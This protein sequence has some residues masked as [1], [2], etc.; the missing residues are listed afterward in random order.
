MVSSSLA[1]RVAL[2]ER[3]DDAATAP[4]RPVRLTLRARGPLPMHR[5]R[6]RPPAWPL[7]RP[8]GPAPRPPPWPDAELPPISTLVGLQEAYDAWA[9]GAIEEL[10]AVLQLPQDQAAALRRQPVRGRTTWTCPSGRSLG[11][12]AECSTKGRRMF[13]AA[14]KARECRD[15]FAKGDYGLG[16]QLHR[17]A[18]QLQALQWLPAGLKDRLQQW[19]F[20]DG[21]DWQETY[22]QL[23]Q[24][25]LDEESKH[26]WQRTCSWRAWIERSLEHGAGKAHRFS[27]GPAG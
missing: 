25:A 24:M 19:A 5:V 14:A 7:T 18:M 13:A 21:E 2:C 26:R 16:H 22:M 17:L 10:V 6:L 23:Q 1:D 3:L 12:H 15:I 9:A 11:A 27:K 8:M 4:H 20:F